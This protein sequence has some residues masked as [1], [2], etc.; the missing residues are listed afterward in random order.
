MRLTALTL[1]RYGNFDNEHIIFDPR[2]GVLNLVLAPNGGGKSVLRAAFCD[3]LFGIGGQT[4]MG[5]RYGY[6]GM[7]IAAEAI[8]PDQEPFGF[9]RRKGRGN[10]LIDSED[11]TLD[12]ARIA[13]LLGRTDRSRLE[14]LFALDTERLRQGEADLLA[15]DGELGSALVSG[16]GGARDLRALR[17]SLE[18]T[19]DALAPTRRSSQR[20]FY[21]ALER[22]VGA[23]RRGEASLLR[24]EQWH[25]HERDLDAAERRRAEQNRI[26]DLESAEIARLERVRRIVPW[27]AARDAAEAWLRAN[28]GAPVLDAAALAP[29]LTEARVAIV[30]ASQRALREQETVDRLAEQIGGIVVD[31]LLLGEAGEIERLSEAT[32]AA[33]KATADLPT[34]VARASALGDVIAARL[35][36]LN[37]AL[38]VDR[39]AEVI[40]PRAVVSRVRRLIQTYAARQE[41]ARAAPGRTAER[42]RERD[43]VAAQQLA[44][45]MPTDV[46]ALEAVVNEIRADGDP[47]RR[48]REAV[49]RRSETAEN[50]AAA[51]ARVPGWTLG[52]AAL[53]ALAPLLP[54]TYERHA[55]EIAEK[56]SEATTRLD[57]LQSARQARDE[58]RD[59]LA[60]V[61]KSGFLPD[62]AALIRA[63]GRRDDGWQLIYRRAFTADP[64]TMPEEQ[65]FAG[66]LPLPLAYERAVTAADAI[67][68]RHI[69]E[70]ELIERAQ[71]A[72]TALH[73]AEARVHHAQ[74]RHEHAR[75]AQDAVER[76]WRQICGILPLGEQ[77]SLRDLHSFLAARDRVIDA[78][79]AHLVAVAAEAALDATHTNW[80]VRLATVLTVPDEQTLFALLAAADERLAE[81]QQ[82]GRARAALTARREVAEQALAE[83]LV[84]QRQADAAMAEWRDDWARAMREL[85]RPPSEDPLVTDDILQVYADLD[86]AYQELVALRERV[87][88]MWRDLTRHAGEAEALASR[89][90]PDLVTTDPPLL[91]AALRQRVRQTG[92]LAKQRDL[93]RE[94]ML[95]ASRSAALAER[96]MADRQAELSAILTLVG[97]E[98][99]EAAEHRLALAAERGR[100]A[101]SL[102]EADLKL[103]ETGDLR[104]LTDLRQEVAATSVEEIPR[105]IEQASQRRGDAQA[106]AQD[107]AATASAL[108]LEMRQLTAETGASDAA[109]DL[110]SAVATMGR[111]LDEALVHHV[112]AEMLEHALL[113][114]EQQDQSTLLQRIGV[115]F[116]RLTRGTYTRVVTEIGD[117]AVTR[118]IL[119]QR[120]YPDERQS[121][122][123]LSEGTRDQLYLALR[124]AA[125]E[126]H[127]AI[128]PSP[129]FIGDDILQT[130]DDDRALAAMQVLMEVSQHVQVI[131]LT[132]H[133]HLLDL[134]ARLPQG[135]VH[136]CR[137]GQVPPPLPASSPDMVRVISPPARVS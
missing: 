79:T 115:L 100:H 43:A 113:A 11:V 46:S 137:T 19:R 51:L 56:R 5:F 92:E 85:G 55:T 114:V 122:R 3:L 26:A 70:A 36:E 102:A 77:P 129:P 126:E 49:A 15:S 65:N 67:A 94:Q 91:V 97:A 125:I 73:D 81:A 63:R 89:V 47:A 133:R 95:D 52:D 8:G 68:D 136:V 10:T 121:V 69:R 105:R 60:A 111:V 75:Q 99:V 109:A 29:R 132:H 90:A 12:P 58:A 25:K 116:S 119:L 34:L 40:P 38:P 41:A 76:N 78:R 30:I 103:H 98:T 72:K 71:A 4:Q 31:D 24:P 134:A 62:D 13:R 112:A 22:F 18:E 108:A 9:G 39:A 82:V 64:P 33:R 1:T 53:V 84:R 45:T 74:T 20:P 44:S 88:G 128:G 2:P 17:K 50:L 93:L 110:Q 37:S 96:Q 120:D 66:P 123:E 42:E 57:A 83:A 87:A 23:R 117:D 118:L 27:L 135:S 107:A 35:R 48:K 59:R 127:A 32:G 61:T 130:F 86:Q 28:P 14:R 7:R 106:A 101:A 131:L 104:P 54:D 6:P 80:S 124:L 21:M 16:A